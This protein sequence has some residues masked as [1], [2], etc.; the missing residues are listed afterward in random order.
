MALDLITTASDNL[1]LIQDRVQRL[2]DLQ[3]QASNGTYGDESLRAINA[4]CNSLVD[5]INRLYLTTEYNGINM[6]LEAKTDEH[7]N[8]FVASETT[9]TEDTTFEELGIVSSTFT[10]Y[11]IDNNEIQAYDIEENDTIQDF[12]NVLNTY[13]FSTKIQNGEITISSAAGNYIK[14]DLADKLGLSTYEQDYVKSATQG[15]EEEQTF[16]FNTYE[17]TTLTTTSTDTIVN[18]ETTFDTQLISTTKIETTTQ[19]QLISTTTVTPTET[20]TTSYVVQTASLMVTK[21]ETGTGI[22]TPTGFLQEVTRIDTSTITALSSMDSTVSLAS[23]TYSIS[24]TE[25]LVQLANMTN[26]GL[27]NDHTFILGADIDLSSIDNWTP[28][29]NSTNYFWGDFDGNGYTISN[30]TINRPDEDFVGLFGWTG[31]YATTIQNLHVNGSI[32]G[33]DETGGI[34]GRGTSATT[35]KNCY[36]DIEVQGSNYV[37]GIVGFKVSSSALENCYSIGNI[38]GDSYVGGIGG[39]LGC[40]ELNNVHS[41]GTITGDS[42]VGGIVGCYTSNYSF[43]SMTLN[44]STTSANVLGNTNSGGLIGTIANSEGDILVTSCKVLS[45]STSINGVFFG[46]VVYDTT[47]T[48]KLKNSTYNSYYDT[49]GIPLFAGDTPTITNVTAVNITPTTTT[50]TA[51]MSTT[52]DDLGINSSSTP[53]PNSTVTI[54]GTMTIEEFINELKS[55]SAVTNAELVDGV[56]LITTA[57]AALDLTT[58]FLSSFSP[59]QTSST[60][61]ILGSQTTPIEYTTVIDSTTT[62]PW[63]YTTVIENTTTVTN[64]VTTTTTTTSVTTTPVSNTLNLSGSTKFEDLGLEN[65]LQVTIYSEGT[66]STILLNKDKTFDEFYT[67][68]ENRGITKSVS[69]GRIILTGEG[70]TYINSQNLIDLLSIDNVIQN[71]ATKLLNTESDTQICYQRLD[72][73]FAPGVVSIQVGSGAD[74]NSQIEVKTAFSMSGYHEFRN[75][76]IDDKNY[77]EQLDEIL[78]DLNARQVEFGAAQNRLMSALDE[79]TITRENLVSSRSTLRD[80]DIAEVSSTYIQQQILQQASATLMATANQSPSIALQLI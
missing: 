47:Y 54:T 70:N 8:T 6:F 15:F 30:L 4:E 80:A 40:S 41:F 28:I 45:N 17:T 44:N 52:M 58:G 73:V 12:F 69:E 53:L 35:I 25:E 24:T 72:G 64:L 39:I 38:T 36:T 34:I 3:E 18:T 1:S 62:V 26:S 76:G 63:E 14:G 13:G 61:T 68:L 2:R 19:T 11:D 49:A 48:I 23:G 75:I 10:I 16:T 42:Y 59:T 22:S 79:I 20:I 5:E 78:E 37:G 50:S 21:T 71:M 7:G 9:A 55:D 31:M 74:A 43:S 57:N 51:T 46:K 66:K 65:T 77:L 67:E 27:I 29:G 56:L 33:G 60:S 32:I